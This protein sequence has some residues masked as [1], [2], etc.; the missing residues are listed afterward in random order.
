MASEQFIM[1]AK[2][3]EQAERYDGKLSHSVKTVVSVLY[4]LYTYIM[5]YPYFCRHGRIYE[6]LRDAREK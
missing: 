2:L 6:E 5:H 3:A 4:D 1:R